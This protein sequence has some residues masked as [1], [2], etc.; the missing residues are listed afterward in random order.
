MTFLN[1]KLMA[2]GYVNSDVKDVSI[3]LK[4]N[5]LQFD[6]QVQSTQVSKT[7]LSEII[8]DEEFE[9]C[10][11]GIDE[12]SHIIVIFLTNTPEDARKTVK[13]IHPAG[14]KEAPIKGIFS[15]R[16]PIRPN[17]LAMSTVKLVKRSKNILEVEGFDAVDKTIILDIKP[18][19]AFSD[20]PENSIT[21]PWV[22]ELNKLFHKMMDGQ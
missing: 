17:P 18:F 20:V 1:T 2:V 13:K 6:K 11:E 10:L 16:S 3:P 22:F 14:I 8:I 4:D 9:E 7:S 19:I 12:F 21:A 15:S 5:D